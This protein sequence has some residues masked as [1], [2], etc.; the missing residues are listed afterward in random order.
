MAPIAVEALPD[1]HFAAF[2]N[3]DARYYA[4]VYANIEKARLQ[5]WDVQQYTLIHNLD[6]DEPVSAFSWSQQV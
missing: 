2:S 1:S 4:L 6:L 5:I 3:N